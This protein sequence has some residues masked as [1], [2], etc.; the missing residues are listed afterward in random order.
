[1]KKIV[2][3]VSKPRE[4]KILAELI[5][6]WED[7]IA[8]HAY[9]YIKR[10]SGVHLLYQ[11]VGSGTEFMCY[12][13]FKIH[14]EPILEKEIEIS[15]EKYQA[16]LDYLI[17]RLK[18]KYSIKHLFGLFLKRLLLYWFNVKIKNPFADKEKSEVCVEA[19]IRMLNDQ[20][21][22]Q[23]TEDPEEVGM[24]E[25]IQVLLKMPGKMLSV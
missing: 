17:L 23:T 9:F 5:M 11:A 13:G 16:L 19:M 10:D 6:W 4:W 3:G 1:M 21:I 22:Y 20:D 2:C 15:E 14:N 8:S 24:R 18:T 25:V 7:S 12:D